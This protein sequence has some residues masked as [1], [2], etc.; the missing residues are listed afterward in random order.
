MQENEFE[1]K[2]RGLMDDLEIAPSAP[3]W[4]YV[5]KRIPKSN[6][7]RRF[8][9]FFFLLLFSDLN[10]TRIS[11]LFDAFQHYSFYDVSFSVPP[12]EARII[13]V[14]PNVPMV[15]LTYPRWIQLRQKHISLTESALQ[16][17]PAGNQLPT[18]VIFPESPMNFMYEDDPEFQQFVSAFAEKHNVNVLFNSAEPDPENK[19]YFNSAVLV[20]T[21]GKEIAQ[22][23]KIY[24]VPFGE[25]VPAPLQSIVPAFVGSFSYGKKYELLPI[26]D[27]NAG[28]MIC[29]ESHFGQLSREFVRRGADVLV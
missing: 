10:T 4:D 29:F 14:Q 23:D 17:V 3:V 20:N 26:G 1:K 13:A 16:A 5:E 6:R 22:Y 9:A 19:K 2:V 21:Q 18:T 11:A 7:R 12:P 15:G 27:A 25:S 8:I 28:V 24:L